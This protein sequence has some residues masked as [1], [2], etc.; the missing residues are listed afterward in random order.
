MVFQFRKQEKEDMQQQV[1]DRNV[2]TSIEFSFSAS[3]RVAL[4]CFLL[5]KGGANVVAPNQQA[6]LWAS[7]RSIETI[8]VLISAVIRCMQWFARYRR[9]SG[10]PDP[11]I[12]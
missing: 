2:S 12:A 11:R 5:P 9:D 6:L 10:S 4:L 7:P 1:T 3:R 8:S